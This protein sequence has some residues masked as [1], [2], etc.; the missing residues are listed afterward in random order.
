MAMPKDDKATFA[1]SCAKCAQIIG[2]DE[3]Y[4]IVE[5]HAV[6]FTPDISVCHNEPTEYER[7]RSVALCQ[8]CWKRSVEA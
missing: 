6:R 7:Q 8:E 5:Y 3:V 2:V 1:A 4:F